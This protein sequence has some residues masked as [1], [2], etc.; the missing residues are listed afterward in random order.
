MSSGA[1]QR[2]LQQFAQARYC[3][4]LKGTHNG[5]AKAAKVTFMSRADRNNAMVADDSL[6]GGKSLRVRAWACQPKEGPRE[7]Q[8][9]EI[10]MRK[11][12]GIQNAA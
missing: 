12:P 11:N 10:P 2:Y 7:K 4:V 3:A 8:F 6:I 1:L 9:R 5:Q